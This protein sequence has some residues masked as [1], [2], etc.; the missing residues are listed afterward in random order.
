MCR[1]AF[2]FPP[3]F[4][5]CDPPEVVAGILAGTVYQQILFLINQVLAVEF[6]HLEIRSELNGVSRTGLLA[7]TAINATREVNAE[8]LRITAAAFIFGGLKRDAIDRTGYRTEVA[9]YA[10]LASIGVA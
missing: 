5:S 7:K 2:V 10:A 3:D 9:G 6:P 4:D 1:L 8:K